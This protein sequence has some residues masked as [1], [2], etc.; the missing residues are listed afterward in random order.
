MLVPLF[1][2][3]Q[4]SASVPQPAEINKN[5]YIFTSPTCGH[6]HRMQREFLPGLKAKY[7]GIVEIIEIDTSKDNILFSETAEKYASPRTCPLWL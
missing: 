1:L 5:V 2:S 7:K 6:C 4:E 3:A